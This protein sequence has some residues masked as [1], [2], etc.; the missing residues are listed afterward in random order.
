M[1]WSD[2]SSLKNTC[3][4]TGNILAQHFLNALD[5]IMFR[6]KQI[7]V[8][9]NDNSSILS[10]VD[11]KFYHS[12]TKPHFSTNSSQRYIAVTNDICILNMSEVNWS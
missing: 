6:M 7:S 2:G 8:L 12:V 4:W 5:P 9:N 1:F 10:S 11:D 3:R